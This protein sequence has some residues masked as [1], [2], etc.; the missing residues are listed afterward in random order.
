MTKEGTNGGDPMMNKIDWLG[1]SLL[2]GVRIFINNS[3]TI[4]TIKNYKSYDFILEQ[5][6]SSIP[7]AK[8]FTPFFHPFR[9]V[10]ARFLG[11]P[12]IRHAKLIKTSK[13][14]AAL[15]INMPAI[16]R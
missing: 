15:L 7:G 6:N 13:L 1:G 4:L 5:P 10:R 12:P 2:Q 3:I 9:P 8:F 11:P 14:P 16:I